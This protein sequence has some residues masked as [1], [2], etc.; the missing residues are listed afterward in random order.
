MKTICTHIKMLKKKVKLISFDK[1]TARLF[2]FI[3][4]VRQPTVAAMR[5]LCTTQFNSLCL[6]AKSSFF[7]V[8]FHHVFDIFRLS[9][10]NK[11]CTMLLF[12]NL[13]EALLF[14]EKHFGLIGSSCTQLKCTGYVFLFRKCTS[15]Y[16]EFTISI[17]KLNRSFQCFSKRKQTVVK[18]SAYLFACL[19]ET[20][21]FSQHVFS[22]VTDGVSLQ[23][24]KCIKYCCHSYWLQ[25]QKH[26]SS[27]LIDR[28]LY[29]RQ[30]FLKRKKMLS[31]A[32]E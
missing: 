18:N 10:G 27:V 24:R 22:L 11:S 23:Q 5:V 13:L 14:T 31:K 16:G 3:L 4:F 8:N 28:D 12:H 29:H 26:H 2:R 15:G 17:V 25:Q 30:N 21:S 32:K 7:T 19:K 6:L 9:F 20:R 1:L